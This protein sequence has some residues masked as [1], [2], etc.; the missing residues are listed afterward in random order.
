MS[1]YQ[2]FAHLAFLQEIQQFLCNYTSLELTS[3]KSSLSSV[4]FSEYCAFLERATMQG[5]CSRCPLHMKP[6]CF[7]FSLTSCAATVLHLLLR[8]WRG[9]LSTDCILLESIGTVKGAILCSS[10]YISL[11]S[12]HSRASF[13]LK[14]PLLCA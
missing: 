7:P 1:Y 14:L 9:M 6:D 13:S 3:S 11:Q 4:Y 8:L 12:S 2:C 10:S 5:T